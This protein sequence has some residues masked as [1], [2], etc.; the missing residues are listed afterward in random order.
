MYSAA[1]F[2]VPFINRYGASAYLFLPVS[3]AKGSSCADHPVN[4]GSSF[5][6]R[7]GRT[8]KYAV[9]GPPHSHFSTPPQANSTFSACT[10]TGTVPSDWKVSSTTMAPTLCAFST[11]AAAS[12]INALRKITCEMGTSSVSSSMASSSRWVLTVTPSSVFTMW[13]RAPC[14]RC[15]SQ[16]YITEGKFMSVYTTLLRLPEK[17]KHE[18]TTAWHWVT[19]WCTDTLPAGAFMSTPISSPTSRE[20]IHHFSSQARTPRVAQMSA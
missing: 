13:T 5:F 15:A 9:P 10:S 8:Y 20:S 16:K 7:S 1:T 19:F 12:W 17:S 18:A 6:P 11:I 2:G 14:A 3:K 4:R